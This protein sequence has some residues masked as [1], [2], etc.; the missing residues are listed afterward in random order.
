MGKIVF[1]LHAH[2]PF[3]RHPEYS[4][5][6]EEDWLFEAISETYLPLLRVF[7]SLDSDG[8]PSRMAVSL[9]PTLTAMLADGLLQDRYLQHLDR[10]IELSESECERNKGDEAFLPLAQMYRD[11][12]L[13]NRHDF[14]EL[15]GKNILRGFADLASRGRIELITTAATHSFLPLYQQYPETIQAQIALGLSSHWQ[16]FGQRPRGMW[17]PECGYYEG[18]ENHLERNGI[19]YFFSASHAVLYGSQLPR[20]GVYAPVQTPNGVM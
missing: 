9:S 5:F 19:E 17:L 18:L 8:I 4:R 10:L 6:L 13:Q 12:F 14:V 3:V 11:L 1:L 16:H 2:L 7:R 20:N 15:Y